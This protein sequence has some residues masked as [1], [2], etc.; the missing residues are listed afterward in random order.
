MRVPFP[1]RSLAMAPD[2]VSTVAGRFHSMAL[3][4]ENVGGGDWLVTVVV[5]AAAGAAHPINPAATSAADLD[6]RASV[7]REKPFVH[8][9]TVSIS[10]SALLPGSS[11]PAAP[12]TRELFT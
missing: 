1:V 10:S 7:C 11:E 3:A 4:T 8:T 6:E 12:A 9:F 2:R 5:C